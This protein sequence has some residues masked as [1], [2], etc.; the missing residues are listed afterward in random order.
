[1]LLTSIIGENRQD[2]LNRQKGKERQGRLNMPRQQG[3]LCRLF[4]V[5][6]VAAVTAIVSAVP[7]VASADDDA[8]LVL[9]YDTTFNTIHRL[10]FGSNGKGSNP[11]NNDNND[12][13]DN[14]DNLQITLPDSSEC[15][16]SQ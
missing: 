2:R 11:D 6:F 5:G 16:E 1:M 4:A 13:T 12:N 8:R 7:A 3:S 14:T 10:V 15:R 9:R